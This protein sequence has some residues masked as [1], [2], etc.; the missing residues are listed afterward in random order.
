MSGAHCSNRRL[1]LKPETDS[2]PHEPFI[3]IPG[4]VTAAVSGESFRD[5]F[6]TQPGR[7]GA[8]GVRFSVA[9]RFAS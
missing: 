2:Q 7:G 6:A 1:R 4:F 5:T 8:P 3:G 9:Q